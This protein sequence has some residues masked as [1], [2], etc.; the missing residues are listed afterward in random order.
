MQFCVHSQNLESAAGAF[1]GVSATAKTSRPRNVVHLAE[2]A[3]VLE[4]LFEFAY[5]WR[6]P[7]IENF[8]AYKVARIAEAAE[9]YDFYSAAPMCQIL[10]WYVRPFVCG[11]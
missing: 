6:H 3:D 11:R 10:L 4:I 1:P 8:G 9:K 7:R 2:D 5:P